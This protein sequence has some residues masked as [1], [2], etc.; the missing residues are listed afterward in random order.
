MLQPRKAMRL[1]KRPRQRPPTGLHQRQIV[2]PHLAMKL[3]AHR[4]KKLSA[5]E[6]TMLVLPSAGFRWNIACAGSFTFGTRLERSILDSYG[7]W[8]PLISRRVAPR[9][10]TCTLE[11]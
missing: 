10:T 7:A 6:K 11:L 4:P 9:L 5:F 2:E 8:A 1:G 3:V